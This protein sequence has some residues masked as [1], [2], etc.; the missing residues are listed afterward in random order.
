MGEE[1]IGEP[2]QPVEGTFDPAA[3]T[4]AEPGLPRRFIWRGTEYTVTSGRNPGRVKAAGLS[5]IYVSTGI[6]LERTP[7]WR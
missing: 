5:N 6:R 1:F 2:I 4:R 7:D 3:M